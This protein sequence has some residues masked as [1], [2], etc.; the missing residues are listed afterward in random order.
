LFRITL[1]LLRPTVVFLLIVGSIYYLR[2]FTQ[3]YNMSY[4]GGGGPLNATKP[5]VLHI[6]N[7][8]FRHFEMG[9]ASA[10]TVILFA[11]IMVITLIELRVTKSH[12]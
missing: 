8:A 4:Q 12:D 2:I 1:P 6:Y 5:I 11:I 10:L 9:Y 3:V 7:S